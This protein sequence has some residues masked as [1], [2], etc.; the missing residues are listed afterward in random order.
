[1][2]KADQEKTK[3]QKDNEKDQD[4]ENKAARAK[5]RKSIAYISTGVFCAAI[6]LTFLIPVN[7]YVSGYG[8]ILSASDAVLRAGSKGPVRRILAQ[9]G[10]RVKKDQV[11]L[12]LEDDVERADAERCRRELDQAK[13]ELE[14]Q[15]AT[16]EIEK[17][18]DAYQKE[19]ARIQFQDSQAEF[20]RVKGLRSSSAT[21][22][23]ELRMATTK[24]DLDK[25]ELANKSIDNQKI[26]LSQVEVQRRKIA[27]LEA[28]VVS[29]DRVLSRRKVYAPMDGVLVMHSLSIGQVVDANEVLGQ[30]FDDQYYQMIAHIPEQFASYLQPGQSIRVELSAYPSWLFDYF[31]GKVSWVAPVVNPQASGDGTVMI[32]AKIEQ[33][34][35][36]TE[37]KAGM[38]GKISVQAGKTSL[39]MRLLGIRTYDRTH[40]NQSTKP[41]TTQPN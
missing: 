1:M 4:R 30:I 2:T 41:A 16:L 36:N 29:A 26:R 37:L 15:T 24:R 20:D 33:L 3:E 22:D 5:R 8:N 27:I 11:I 9:S 7:F 34:A 23:L 31:W 17:Q 19:T 28:Q 18:R 21:S 38:S 39:L 32:K 12:E 10:Q 13:A 25:I 35:P 6:V 40:S 14:L